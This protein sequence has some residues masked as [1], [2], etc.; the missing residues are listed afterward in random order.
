M[1]YRIFFLQSRIQSGPPGNESAKS[2]PLRHQG[3][4]S[5]IQI[6]LKVSSWRAPLF[7]KLQSWTSPKIHS[8]Q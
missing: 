1:A 3:I 7:T 4:P 6:F 5:P 2:Q 8:H